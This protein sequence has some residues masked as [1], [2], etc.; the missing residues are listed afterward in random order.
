MP[1]PL[2]HACWP[3]GHVD[4][5]WVALAKASLDQLTSAAPRYTSKCKQDQQSCP[6]QPRSAESCRYL[7][8]KCWLL[9]VTQ[10]LWWSVMQQKLTDT[11]IVIALL[12]RLNEFIHVK[13]SEQWVGHMFR[14]SWVWHEPMPCI[15][16]FY[17]SRI[18]MPHGS[19]CHAF[20]SPHAWKESW[21]LWVA[22]MEQTSYHLPQYQNLNAFQVLL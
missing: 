1:L 3:I 22:E 12:W 5:S 4:W 20:A 17:P 7:R 15:S 16:V 6:A 8:N 11:S 21:G 9:Y 19:T 10:G 2:P 18:L 14:K 13:Y